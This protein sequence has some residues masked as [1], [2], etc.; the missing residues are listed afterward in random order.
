MPLLR[1]GP[2]QL[3]GVDGLYHLK[4]LGAVVGKAAAVTTTE[5][6]TVQSSAQLPRNQAVH[7]TNACGICRPRYFCAN[8][9]R[10]SLIAR[11]W[12]GSFEC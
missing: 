5:A 8:Q 6:R 7:A 3:A 11:A 2:R 4:Q 12:I 1:F 10:A 9:R